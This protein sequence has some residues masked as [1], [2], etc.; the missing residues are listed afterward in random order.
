MQTNSELQFQALLTL[1]I[2]VIL[3]AGRWAD[4]AG[5][6]SDGK[7][8]CVGRQVENLEPS[9]IYHAADLQL[10]APLIDALQPTGFVEALDQSGDSHR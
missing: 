6:S 1:L 7:L 9:A 10:P 4:W 3:R 2:I 8:Q 5:F